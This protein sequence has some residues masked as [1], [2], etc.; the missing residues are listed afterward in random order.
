MTRI[1]E[2]SRSSARR[3]LLHGVAAV[4]LLLMTSTGSPAWAGEADGNQVDVIVRI[5]PACASP[6]ACVDEPGAMLPSTGVASQ[7]LALLGTGTVMAGVLLAVGARRT[8][9][10]GP[11]RT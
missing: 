4:G 10:A 3:F 8:R 9:S 6:A 2:R 1:P 7:A 5:A 11:E